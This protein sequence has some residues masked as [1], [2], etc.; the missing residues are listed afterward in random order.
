MIMEAARLTRSICSRPDKINNQLPLAVLLYWYSISKNNLMMEK[1]DLCF[2]PLP[3]ISPIH[4]HVRS[5]LNNCYLESLAL[6]RLLYARRALSLNITLTSIL[7]FFLVTCH[8]SRRE[9]LLLWRHECS[10]YASSSRIGYHPNHPSAIRPGSRPSSAATIVRPFSAGC[11]SQQRASSAVPLQSQTHESRG[12]A[13][14]D[15][16]DKQGNIRPRSAISRLGDSSQPTEEVY[17]DLAPRP[18]RG[19]SAS[20]R[21]VS[22]GGGSSGG[23]NRGRGDRDSRGGGSSSRRL[24]NPQDALSLG[25]QEEEL[26]EEIY[27]DLDED[28]GELDNRIS[29][30]ENRFSTVGRERPASSVNKL[31]EGLAST[32]D[33]SNALQRSQEVSTALR[34]ARRPPRAYRQA[35]SLRATRRN[36]SADVD[37]PT[38]GLAVSEIEHPISCNDATARKVHIFKSRPTSAPAGGSFFYEQRSN[39]PIADL[40]ARR[41]RLLSADAGDHYLVRGGGT[42]E[43]GC[44]QEARIQHQ[45]QQQRQQDELFSRDVRVWCTV[46]NVTVVVCLLPLH[47]AFVLP[48][49]IKSV[50]VPG[51]SVL[52]LTPVVP[53]PMAYIY[54]TAD[55][56]R[57]HSQVETKQHNSLLHVKKAQVYFLHF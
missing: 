6:W 28:D 43:Q 14:R 33:N 36:V 20:G 19:A 32:F 44:G 40:Y 26:Y 51:R 21:G 54:S 9:S 35:S 3:F 7:H 25:G 45:H 52:P 15:R 10:R 5:C 57:P 39:D 24:S 37:G 53:L 8:R 31:D 55:G 47:W 50:N 56:C 27:E 17:G 18:R 42:Q 1:N 11:S 49:E 13:G 30:M 46:A 29:I 34:S 4:A 23:M 22:S 38:R 48:H 41:M 16:V 2:L 12:V